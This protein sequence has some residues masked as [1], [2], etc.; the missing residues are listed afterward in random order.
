MKYTELSETQQVVLERDRILQLEGEH[1][2]IELLLREAPAEELAGLIAKQGEL[3]RRIEL[4][5]APDS[6]LEMADGT[7]TVAAE[8]EASRS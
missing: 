4:H 7:E 8:L 2:R 5:R 6:D 3:A 1:Y